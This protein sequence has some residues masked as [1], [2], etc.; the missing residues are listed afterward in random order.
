VKDERK[1]KRELI[2]ELEGLRRQL[3]EVESTARLEAAAERI[4]AEV[5]AMQSSE[6]LAQVMALMY[7][8]VLRLG[9][10][11]R[12]CNVLFFDEER[13]QVVNYHASVNP[14]TFGDWHST[15]PGEVV[16]G[17]AVVGANC[18]RL[19]RN[20][21]FYK[22]WKAGEA[23]SYK[24]AR[25]E[26]TLQHYT[27]G[28]PLPRD[29]I[30]KYSG[31][32][33]VVNIPFAHGF[34]G[35]SE[36]ELDEDHVTIVQ[37]LT[38]SLSLG[39]LRFLD[40]QRLEEH[41]RRLTEERGL[42]SVRA[43]VASMQEGDDLF[44]VVERVEEAL[45]SLEIS[46][47]SY[48]LNVVDE[49]AEVIRVYWHHGLLGELTDIGETTPDISRLYQHWKDGEVYQR[50]LERES[51]SGWVVDVPFAQGMLAMGGKQTEAYSDSEIA[52]LRRLAGIVSLGYGRFLDFQSVD[53]AQRKLIDELEEE[54]QTAHDLQQGLMPAESP[55]V[56][57]FDIAGRCVPA[58]HVGGDFFQYYARDGKLSICMADVTGHAMEA[59]V[60]V[61]M[62]SGVLESEMRHGERPDALFANLNRTLR[63][64]L[65][66]H[67]FVCCVVG[68]LEG[69]TLRLAN[70]G[71][72]HPYLYRAADSTVEELQIHAYPLGVQAETEYRVVE[73][74]LAPGDRVVLSSDGFIEA[75]NEDEELFGFDRM[76]EAVRQSG[77]DGLSAAGLI[78]R[79]VDEVRAFAG[80]T[81]QGDDMTCVV[82]AVED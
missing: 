13:D 65:Q 32:W 66:A 30:D 36:R 56:E 64:K 38:Q 17:D 42:E 46:A 59:A 3:L 73:V 26:E 61:M 8:E 58:N 28:A 54:L 55:R 72:P 60:P 19:D 79:I 39:Y 50:F 5:M 77:A 35:F 68:E 51:D 10:D 53:E 37:R 7:R 23:W 6:N 29:Y 15:F 14:G 52:T 11:S 20:V 57:G 67:T 31:E 43:E 1:T 22:L 40:F 4:R 44:R 71:C 45:Q 70:G 75:Q 9:I 24:D 25:S 80:E 27:G 12:S 41:N 76:Q 21:D 81:P 48:S 2:T 33:S 34:V 74:E 82:L 49:A 63:S 78:D 47:T 62:F 69:H 16:D 18:H